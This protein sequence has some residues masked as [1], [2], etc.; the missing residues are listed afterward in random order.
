MTN[1]G[2]RQTEWIFRW[3]FSGDRRRHYPVSETRLCVRVACYSV[4]DATRTR[5][6]IHASFLGIWYLGVPNFP[7]SKYFS[8]DLP[9]AVNS[10]LLVR[11]HPHNQVKTKLSISRAAYELIQWHNERIFGFEIDGL[12]IDQ[13]SSEDHGVGC[14]KWNLSYFRYATRHA[15]ELFLNGGRRSWEQEEGEVVIAAAVVK[16]GY[17]CHGQVFK[18]HSSRFL[19]T[20]VDWAYSS[21]ERFISWIVWT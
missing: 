13:N 7:F 11:A 12:S 6:L 10:P 14:W 2:S 21:L 8:S 16:I 4:H 5:L 18:F 1:S 3:Q 15:L 19:F 9:I 17:G 20:F